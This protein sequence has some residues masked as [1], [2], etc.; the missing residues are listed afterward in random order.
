MGT[1]GSNS[2]SEKVKKYER[3][4][5]VRESNRRP[6]KWKAIVCKRERERER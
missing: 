4:E 1:S 6:K 5:I 2:E 3:G